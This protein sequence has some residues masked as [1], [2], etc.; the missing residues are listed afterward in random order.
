MSSPFATEPRNHARF[1]PAQARCCTGALMI[2]RPVKAPRLNERRY[3]IV[4]ERRFRDRSG[5][6]STAKRMV[7]RGATQCDTDLWCMTHTHFKPTEL[8]DTSKIKGPV[9]FRNWPFE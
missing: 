8:L 3:F 7:K 4:S 6:F 9:P 1:F 2:Q 5:H